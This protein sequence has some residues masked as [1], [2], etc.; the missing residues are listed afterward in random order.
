MENKFTFGR[1]SI[2]PGFRM[3]LINQDVT[4]QNYSPTTGLPTTGRGKS[5]FD[6]Q[7]LFGL[8][9]EAAVGCPIV[10]EAPG[11]LPE[12]GNLATMRDNADLR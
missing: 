7:P 10:G 12:V 9:R 6:P 4:T 11:T 5:K 2:T 8:G 3:E 1:L